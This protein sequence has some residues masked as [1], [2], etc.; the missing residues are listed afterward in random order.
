MNNGLVQAVGMKE[1]SE[2]A[3]WFHGNINPVLKHI[4]Q[5]QIIKVLAKDLP[6]AYGLGIP[7]SPYIGRMAESLVCRNPKSAALVGC[8]EWL[9]SRKAVAVYV[10]V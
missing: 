6:R 8:E 1:T 5:E 10:R 9:L 7:C 2:G 3:C 4:W